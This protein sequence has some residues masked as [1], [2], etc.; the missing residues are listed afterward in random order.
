M[1]N[2]KKKNEKSVSER[3][4]RAMVRKI[5]RE[6]ISGRTLIQDQ[7]VIEIGKAICLA[8]R[9]VKGQTSLDDLCKSNLKK[10]FILKCKGD[11]NLNFA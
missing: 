4:G 9:Y 2:L 7:K 10:P 5:F 6:K 8:L 11:L 1:K 3:G